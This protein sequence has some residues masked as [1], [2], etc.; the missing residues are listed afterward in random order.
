MKYLKT[1]ASWCNPVPDP[2]TEAAK[3]NSAIIHCIIY[4]YDY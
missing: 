1:Q 3:W 2:E 4:T